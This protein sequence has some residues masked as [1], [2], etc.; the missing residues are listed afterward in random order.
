LSPILAAAG[1]ETGP[2]SR[3]V[4]RHGQLQDGRLSDKA[5]AKVVK[6]T[7]YAAALAK[8]ADEKTAEGA[9]VVVTTLTK[10]RCRNSTPVFPQQARKAR[11]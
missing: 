11:L 8:G 4:N 10:P 2:V 3:W 1:L 5:V 6:R 7:A 9:A